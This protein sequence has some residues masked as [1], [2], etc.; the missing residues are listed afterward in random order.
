MVQGENSNEERVAGP[1]FLLVGLTLL[2]TGVGLAILGCKLENAAVRQRSALSRFSF[3]SGPR[4]G[5]IF[6]NLDDIRSQGGDSHHNRRGSFFGSS[7]NP[8]LS[9]TRRSTL[10][11]IAQA[12]P[13]GFF[14]MESQSPRTPKS[15]SH[16]PNPY[17][18]G[19]NHR[20]STVN[21]E[22]S[23]STTKLSDE[24][25]D[26]ELGSPSRDDDEFTLPA[27]SLRP[28]IIPIPMFVS[29]NRR[30]R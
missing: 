13:H 24:F 28:S 6:A 3:E 4:S 23:A 29:P 27:L 21:P 30:M 1:L 2:V 16:I 5:D 10:A 19:Y 8:S 15:P 12:V 9:S 11:T 26:V 7:F 14:M 22:A 20:H 18:N 17:K 25:Q